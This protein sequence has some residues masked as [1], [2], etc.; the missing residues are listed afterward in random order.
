[1][2]SS[3]DHPQYLGLKTTLNTVSLHL[4][5][6]VLLCQYSKNFDILGVSFVSLVDSGN[7]YDK[8][9]IRLEHFGSAI[10]NPLCMFNV[11][12]FKVD[13]K[14]EVDCT[15]CK[16]SLRDGYECCPRKFI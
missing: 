16:L 13:L 10:L 5:Y 4:F 12:F 6:W 15:S 2:L 11:C 1:M 7:C 3:A 9:S 14:S 8:P